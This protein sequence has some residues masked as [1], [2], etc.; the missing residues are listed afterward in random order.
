MFCPESAVLFVLWAVLGKGVLWSYWG[1]WIQPAHFVV[2]SCIHG[3]LLAWNNLN[4][5]AHT[6]GFT[7][8]A[9][10]RAFWDSLEQTGSIPAHVTARSCSTINVVCVYHTGMLSS[11]SRLLSFSRCSWEWTFLL[12]YL[13]SYSLKLSTNET[14]QPLFFS[15]SSYNLLASSTAQCCLNQ[16]W[17]K[18]SKDRKRLFLLLTWCEKFTVILGIAG[19]KVCNH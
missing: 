14:N 6:K 11:H 4:Y 18:K 5:S 13:F 1:Y 7:W 17:A 19:C 15:L 2:V 3:P 10:S 9:R 8:A 12:P 16:Q